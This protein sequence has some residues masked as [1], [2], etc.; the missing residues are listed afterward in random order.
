MLKT[1]T[2]REIGTIRAALAFWQRAGETSPAILD[3]ASGGGQ[4]RP[5]EPEEV[6]EL[7]RLLQ[8]APRVSAQPVDDHVVEI[9]RR[10]AAVDQMFIGEHAQIF[11]LIDD[12][13][14]ILEADERG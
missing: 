8:I 1:L 13:R 4:Y 5:L 11:E 3:L 2:P 14:A 7:S 6:H 10:L 9:V 12:A